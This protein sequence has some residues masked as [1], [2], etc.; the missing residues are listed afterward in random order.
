L[1]YT[2][3]RVDSRKTRGL[4]SK[5]V[6]LKWYA[7]IR[8]VGFG[9]SGT[10][11]RGWGSGTGGG[12]C[13]PEVT[14]PVAAAHRRWPISAIWAPSCTR[15]GPGESSRHRESYMTSR[16]MDRGRVEALH[17]GGGT[18]PGH[19][20]EEGAL[21]QRERGRRGTV[22]PLPPRGATTMIGGQRSVVPGSNHGGT[23][24][25]GGGHGRRSRR[26]A[27]LRWPGPLDHGDRFGKLLQF[28]NRPEKRQWIRRARRSR[29]AGH[30][31]N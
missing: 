23:R 15:S 18:R 21:A 31:S 8:V 9:S 7:L 25:I 5:K 2:G 28:G 20:G 26:K 22:R 6:R 24:W 29:H 17:S 12:D 13:S 11:Q 4:F 10:E 27:M 1:N 30:R 14:P 16:A 3:V 19:N